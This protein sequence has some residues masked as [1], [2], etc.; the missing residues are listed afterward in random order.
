M[1]AA[2]DISLLTPGSRLQLRYDTSNADSAKGCTWRDV[3]V[4]D[5]PHTKHR[6]TNGDVITVDHDGEFK[7]FYVN[8]IMEAR[9]P[10]SRARRLT[11][12]DLVS[13]DSRE[14]PDFIPL[15]KITEVHRDNTATIQSTVCRKRVRVHIDALVRKVKG[16]ISK[17]RR[18]RSHGPTVV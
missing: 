5:G 7:I 6:F 1:V 16:A 13:V 17:R 2:I 15:A 12:G 9:K 3:T 10:P 11:E 14:T 8:S 4:I 18:T